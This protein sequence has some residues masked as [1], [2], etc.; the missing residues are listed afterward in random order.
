MDESSDSHRRCHS[1]CLTAPSLTSTRAHTL[2]HTW[3][4]AG[5]GAGG[6]RCCRPGLRLTLVLVVG[7]TGWDPRSEQLSAGPHDPGWPGLQVDE[8]ERQNTKSAQMSTNWETPWSKIHKERCARL[9]VYLAE[10]F[11]SMMS[12]NLLTGGGKEQIY[13][14]LRLTALFVLLTLSFNF[15][16]PCCCS[17]FHEPN[18]W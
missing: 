13:R 3:S 16:F 5:G 11:L 2:G 12:A 1:C 9:D 14:T 15:L 4:L 6:G 10:V 7:R 17:A 18:N 8:T